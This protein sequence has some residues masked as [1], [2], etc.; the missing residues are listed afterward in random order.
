MVADCGSP[1][2][3]KL[4]YDRCARNL[5]N[6]H[7]ALIKNCRDFSC[8]SHRSS[9]L[10]RQVLRSALG[11]AREKAGYASAMRTKSLP[12]LVAYTSM[13]GSLERAMR[14]GISDAIGNPKLC[15]GGI[16]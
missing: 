14:L 13:C 3:S 10:G 11:S 6:S 4:I 16:I 15:G 12:H 9:K 1:P 5:D 2:P 7:G 8:C